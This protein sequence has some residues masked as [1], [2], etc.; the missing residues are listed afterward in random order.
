[1]VIVCVIYKIVII[2]MFVYKYL[3]D[4]VVDEKIFVLVFVKIVIYDDG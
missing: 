1:M 2:S 4:V 3:V